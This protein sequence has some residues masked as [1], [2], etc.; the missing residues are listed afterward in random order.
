MNAI[1][2]YQTS[3]IAHLSHVA[4]HPNMTDKEIEL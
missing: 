2:Q 1:G 4:H 3:F